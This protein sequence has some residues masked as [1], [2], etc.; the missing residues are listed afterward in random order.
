MTDS[1]DAG[2]LA[3]TSSCLT[4]FHVTSMALE[5]T[6][7]SLDEAGLEGVEKTAVNWRQAKRWEQIRLQK[8]SEESDAPGTRLP[9]DREHDSS[10]DIDFNDSEHESSAFFIQVSYIPGLEILSALLN[11]LVL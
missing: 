7:S 8:R 9:E 5:A 11:D 10:R 2:E 4:S 1:M 3:R 6:L